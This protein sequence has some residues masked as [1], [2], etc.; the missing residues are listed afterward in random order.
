MKK[1]DTTQTRQTDATPPLRIAIVLSTWNGEQYLPEL[2]ESLTRQTWTHW[3]LWVRDDGSNDGTIGLLYEYSKRM[4]REASGNRVLLKKGENTGVVSS[5]FTLLAGIHG[6]YAAYAFCDQDDVW[7]PRKLERAVAAIKAH[8]SGGKGDDVPFLYH[9]GQWLEDQHSGRRTAS[10]APARTGFANALVQNQVVGC[11]MV[12]NPSLRECLLIGIAS[13]MENDPVSDIIMHDWWCYLLASGFGIITYDPEPVI[14]FRRHE[15]STTPVAANP[16]RMIQKRVSSLKR[17][18]WSVSHIMK[19][20]VIFA[21][22]YA[23]NGV[24]DSEYAGDRTKDSKA[25]TRPDCRLPEY[26]ARQLRSLINLS[27]CG[28][29]KRLSYLFAGE[30]KRSGRMDTLVFRLMVFMRRF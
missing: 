5:F 30:H 2:L 13:Q 29:R 4:E 17:R 11:T 25:D 1:P 16:F 26:K 3:D 21:A 12:I 9:A 20:A 24:Q 19:Q 18:A 8:H 10:P 14:H 6:E 15:Q 28:F 22:L 23:A 27:K 7:L